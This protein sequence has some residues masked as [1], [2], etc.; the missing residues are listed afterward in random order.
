M[1]G[2]LKTNFGALDAPK[3]TASLAEDPG[4]TETAKP[5][6]GATGAR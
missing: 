2:K 4:E 1:K 3:A 6:P 5:P